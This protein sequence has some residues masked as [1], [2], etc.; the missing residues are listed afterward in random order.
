MDAQLYTSIL[1]DE[2][3]K[4]LE[5][6]GLEIDKIIFQQ[7]NDSKHTSRLAPCGAGTNRKSCPDWIGT[8]CIQS[9]KKR[10][11]FG[12]GKREVVNKTKNGS[13]TIRLMAI[14]LNHV[15]LAPHYPLPADDARLAGLRRRR[16]QYLMIVSSSSKPVA[17]SHES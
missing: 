13:N 2:L 15:M 10:V 5:H 1:D 11:S 17:G 14:R 3:L 8:K 4:T 7:D 6:Y 9:L 16:F 12:K